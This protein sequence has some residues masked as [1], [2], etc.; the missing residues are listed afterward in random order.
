MGAL[1]GDPCPSSVHYEHGKLQPASPAHATVADTIGVDI[2]SGARASGVLP[3]EMLV[4][5]GQPAHVF[6]PPPR[7]LCTDNDSGDVRTSP[8]EVD[9]SSNEEKP[10]LKK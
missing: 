8:E 10:G 9:V 6:D 7:P 1:P 5:E 3:S 4:G 2:P